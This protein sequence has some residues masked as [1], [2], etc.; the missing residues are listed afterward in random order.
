MKNL[1]QKITKNTI[2]R[3]SF[4]KWSAAIAATAVVS[5]CES[6]LVEI[7]DK[8]AKKIKKDSGKWI[9]AA[10][11]HNCGGRCL[12]KAHV[13]DGTVTK[14]KTDD[15]K[16][17]SEYNL[18]QRACARGR[19][20]RKQV[21]GA[22]RL[23][24][25]MKR[26]NWSSGGGNKELRG[27]DTW[28]RISWDEAT[29]IVSEEIK[30]TKENFGNES[31][32]LVH[33]GEM[34]RTLS[35]FGG[36]VQ[37]YGSRSR[38][39]WSKAMK[40]ILGVKQ[41]RHI[42]N[43]RMDMLNSK[44]IVLWGNNPAW[45]SA[46]N[47]INNFLKAKEKGIKFICID[48]YYSATASALADEF[49]PIRPATDTTMLLAIAYVLITEDSPQTPLIDWDFLNRCTVGFDINHMPEG[50]NPKENFKDYVLGTYDNQPKTPEWASEI[51]GVPASKI[52]SFALELGMSKPA[53]VL[54]GWNSAR[55]EKGQHVCLAQTCVGAMTG[56]MGIKGGAFGIS[57][58]EPASNGGPYLVKPGKDGLDKIENPLKS[59]KLC[60]NN[61]WNAILTNKY[62]AGKDDVRDID[63]RLIYHS[64]SS[65]LNQTNNIN[66][67]IKAH[68]KVDFVVT[69]QY[70][71]NPN[72]AYS[73]VVLPV[74][75][76]W[77]R[78]GT[79]LTGNREILIWAS[80][81]I[82][83]LFE[84]KDDMWIAKEIGK[85]LGIDESKIEPVSLKQRIFNKIAG[86]EVIKDDA[87]DYEPLVKITAQDIEELGVIGNTQS[88]RIPIMEFREKGIYQVQRKPDDKFV[89]I[90]NKKFREDPENNPLETETGK[91][92][93]HCRELA[94][95][96][97]KAGWNE[98]CPIAKYDS[99]T[100]G[101]EATF[102][103]WDKK[104][105]G[106]YP[107]QLCSYHGRRQTH[108]V[109]GNVPWLRESFENDLIMNPID[110]KI[111]GLKE[112][113]TI[114][115]FNDHGSI[116]RRVHITE[117]V[118]PGVV[119]L[120]QGAWVDIDEEGNCKSGATNM[121]TGDYPSG[122]DIESWQACIVEVKKH[123]TQLDSDYK[124]GQR[125]VKI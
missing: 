23:K 33:G 24:Y 86:A 123:H 78:Y 54:F 113:D 63:I 114:R 59:P 45:S 29:T 67:G 92:Q 124:W 83:P 47:P 1:I 3:R 118:M 65:T 37:K 25:P 51:C 16:A 77:E 56:N 35:L 49:I 101:Y 39:A 12:L 2:S 19:A 8:D 74:T 119:M 93:L 53:T 68:R 82:N 31:I 91:I 90:H 89:Y 108:S 22:D 121:L 98:G 26:T 111:R 41:K 48:P 62:I 43:G 6:G 75:T 46:G 112:K 69:N 44:L 7:S 125:I 105:K 104:I 70:V 28:Q 122:P 110:A 57:C 102:Y 58:Q 81:A 21:F 32:Y 100:E 116:L 88:G 96:V 99:P 36:Y 87:S 115:V 11:W 76:E 107:L 9:S 40:P 14:L 95:I 38:G 109:M 103:D 84:A 4:L 5:G 20:Q 50:A 72:A 10:C 106:N 17:D 66:K 94:D 97:T 52:H 61:H 80:Q 85:K 79:V 120:A 27:K 55:V 73:D 30:R 13:Q 34:S 18:Q 42:I 60:T 71:L 15:I 117:R 64:H